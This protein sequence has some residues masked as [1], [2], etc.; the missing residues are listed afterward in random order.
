MEYQARPGIVL[1]KVCK[2]ILLVPTRSVYD[3]C[4]VVL[5]LPLLDAIVWNAIVRGKS[6]EDILR[7][8]EGIRISQEEGER[9]LQA[10][11][12][13]LLELGFLIPRAENEDAPASAAPGTEQNPV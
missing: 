6:R 8:Y 12:Q 13:R 7:F 3:K 4:S 9:R 1:L 5:R 11:T 2:A 10:F